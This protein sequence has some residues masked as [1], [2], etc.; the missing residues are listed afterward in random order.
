MQRSKIQNAGQGSGERWPLKFA[1]R[2]GL[3]FT[4]TW[5]GMTLLL[6]F[7]FV[8]LP[9]ESVKDFVNLGADYMCIQDVEIR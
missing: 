9:K 3:V 2:I 5:K 8:L 4:Q 6:V 1:L 7:V